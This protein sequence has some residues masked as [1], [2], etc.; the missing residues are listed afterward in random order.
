M[1]SDKSLTTGEQIDSQLMEQV[2]NIIEEFVDA[3]NS[4]DIEKAY[5]LLSDECKEELYPNKT[6][7]E[8]RYIKYNFDGEFDKIAQIENWSEDIYKVMLKEDLMSTGK[9][10]T[11][12]KQDYITIT[13]QNGELKI[14]TNGFIGTEKIDSSNTQDGITITALEKKLFMDYEEYTIRIENRTENKI[15]L[16]TL[17]STK[18]IYLQDIN[19][20]KYYSHSN[21]IVKK[22]L[23]IQ[24]GAST[25]LKI[26]FS[27]SYNTTKINSIVF[28]DLVLNYNDYLS[29]DAEKQIFILY[30]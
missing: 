29:G 12:A 10:S 21:E 6:D 24:S 8:N 18:T 15:L 4:K 13:K 11:E 19:E 2:N 30:L 25:Q 3:C 17:E 23:E 20:M 22:L 1:S 28:S 14:N 9:V 16:D 5:N 7:F 26:K 27:R